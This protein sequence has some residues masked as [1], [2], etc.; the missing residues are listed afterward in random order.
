MDLKSAF[1]NP[2]IIG[3]G[4]ALGALLLLSRGSAPAN[5]NASFTSALAAS[6]AQAA[7]QFQASTAARVAIGSKAYDTSATVAGFFA[8][9]LA[10]LANVNGQVMLGQM[11]S[12]NGVVN[13]S[14]S[15]NAALA[16]DIGTNA[17]RTASASIGSI[18][19][20]STIGTN[21]N[22]SQRI[23]QDASGANMWASIANT[24]GGVAVAAL[25]SNAIGSPA[26]G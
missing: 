14:N 25:K 9:T 17:S 8:S 11:T 22:A 21:A 24:V 6:N 4:L 13:N 26:R 10:N 5:N 18:T 16:I 2:W 7:S 23:A 3:G 1:T 19:G 15:A 20:I 12:F